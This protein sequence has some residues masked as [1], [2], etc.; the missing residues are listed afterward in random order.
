MES[1][2]FLLPIAPTWVAALVPP[3]AKALQ[4]SGFEAED[5]PGGIEEW[6][7]AG[8]PVDGT[9]VPHHAMN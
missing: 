5:Y 3:A 9:E 4:E 8:L 6:Y 7:A 2:V 1:T